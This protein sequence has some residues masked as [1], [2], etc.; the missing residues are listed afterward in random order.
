[1]KLTAPG[2]LL[3]LLAAS[4]IAGQCAAAPGDDGGWRP[5]VLSVHIGAMEVDDQS[6]QIDDSDLT[7]DSE[8]DFSTLPGGGI[9]VEMPFTR[10]AVE[11]G[12]ETGAGIAW[13]NDG[14][15][16]AG[17][18]VDGNTTIRVD[19][20]NSFLLLDYDLGLFARFR[21]GAGMSV[22]AGG[23]GA[24]VYGRHE[25]E[26]EQTDPDGAA[27]T[28]VILN[29]DQSSDFGVGYYAR[30]GIDYTGANGYGFGIGARWLGAELDFDETIGEADVDGV[31]YCLTFTQRLD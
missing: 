1:M 13:R 5:S 24:L 30:V 29:D 4:L 19:I 8:L 28:I 3:S 26:D 2:Q 15:D 16:I 21:L 17:R 25:V 12:L 23:G 22:Y 10:G 20:E 27:G 11:A 6:V 18:S 7:G 31:F 14:T 9:M